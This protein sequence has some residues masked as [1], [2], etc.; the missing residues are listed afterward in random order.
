MLTKQ[1]FTY[2][3]RKRI[4]L[5]ARFT[6]AHF[7]YPS[8]PFSQ[9]FVADAVGSQELICLA[10][11]HAPAVKLSTACFNIPLDWRVLGRAQDV[12][13]TVLKR[14]TFVSIWS[15]GTPGITEVQAQQ[16]PYLSIQAWE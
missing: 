16:A 13:N 7:F 4:S 8:D 10:T 12:M 1:G 2:A 5:D 3:Q 14:P 9:V 6:G 15:S 11:Q